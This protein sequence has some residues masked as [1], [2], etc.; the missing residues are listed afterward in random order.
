M[1]KILLYAVII[2]CVTACNTSPRTEL[3]AIENIK[4]KPIYG[5]SI[6]NGNIIELT[7]I[8]TAM[9]DEMKMDLKIRGKVQ[10]VCKEKGCWMLMK[11]SN[12][13][14]MRVTFKDY[15]IF[16]P[17]DLIGK[18]VV[19]DGFAFRDTTTVEKLQHY[20]REGGKSKEEIAAI[21]YPKVGLAFEAKGVAVMN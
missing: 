6:P 20:A 11:L 9:K 10:Q 1:K 12:G 14:D 8:S 16:V 5:D 17:Q 4:G 18:E 13:D 2:A 15:K 7:A 19:L 3:H 21:K